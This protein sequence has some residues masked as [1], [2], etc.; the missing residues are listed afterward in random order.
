MPTVDIKYSQ[1]GLPSSTSMP[2]APRIQNSSAAFQGFSEVG[3]VIKDYLQKQQQAK[4]ATYVANTG[5]EVQQQIE[6]LRKQ[7]Q[8]EFASNPEGFT[9]S[10]FDDAKKIYQTAIDKS[11]S[12]ESK[13]AMQSQL[14]GFARG[15]FTQA[16]AWEQR[17]T[18]SNYLTKHETSVNMLSN[19]LIENPGSAAEVQNLH[20]A[21]MASARSFLDPTEWDKL[22]DQD[23]RQLA[24]SHIGGVMERSPSAARQLL[25]SGQYA[26][27]LSGLETTQLLSQ[28]DNKEQALLAKARAAANRAQEATMNQVLLNIH[29]AGNFDDVTSIQGQLDGLLDTGR[30][31]V[32]EYIA[33]SDRLERRAKPLIE[34]EAGKERVSS[35][36][37]QGLPLAGSSKKDQKAVDAYYEDVFSSTLDPAKPEEEPQK[38]ALFASKVGVVPTQVKSEIM[39]NL[40]SGNPQNRIK[41]ADKLIQITNQAPQLRREFDTKDFAVAHKIYEGR[42]AGLTPEE[43]V[44]AA[45]NSVYNRDS[46]QY[47]LLA[48]EWRSAAKDN[49]F[50]VD[51]LEKYWTNDPGSSVA[52]VPS[53]MTSDWKE[54]YRTYYVDH[55]MS[56]KKAQELAYKTLSSQWAITNVAGEPRWQRNAP[57]VA[58]HV[59]GQRDPH[60]M[61]QDLKATL[62]SA[63]K[64]EDDNK[65]METLNKV[66]V[67]VDPTTQAS[68]HPSYNLIYWDENGKPNTI[69]NSRDGATPLK[70]QPSWSDS[71]QLKEINARSSQLENELQVVRKRIVDPNNY[72]DKELSKDR[73]LRFGPKQ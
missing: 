12:R 16:N 57:E 24:M 26:G 61:K 72:T 36:L 51:N 39:S 2:N 17:A 19:R 70:W 18:V 3:A 8:Q 56:D 22:K 53:S 29:R 63:L 34:K 44:K 60:W 48:A 49:T 11:P 10:F 6:A 64:I 66:S 1:S 13:M 5:I 40:Y 31:G 59:D 42:N 47:Q 15:D 9:Q 73:N 25:H 68:K 35:A 55:G 50:D 30:M 58:Y 41:A 27:V 33:M 43:A 54:L 65:L 20:N 32:R 38:L 62:R 4:D 21:L 37:S 71:E 46:N 7:K 14:A 52:D 28:A 69:M 67:V 45:Q 23:E